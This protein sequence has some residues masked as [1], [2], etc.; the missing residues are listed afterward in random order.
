MKLNIQAVYDRAGLELSFHRQATPARRLRMR[1]RLDS[2]TL[3][4]STRAHSTRTT[5][6]TARTN[7]RAR[8]LKFRRMAWRQPRRR[9]CS[10][11]SFPA[12]LKRH[13]LQ[14]VNFC[15]WFIYSRCTLRVAQNSFN[16][17]LVR[18]LGRATCLLPQQI[19]RTEKLA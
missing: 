7:E 12:A 16:Y 19:S 9:Q 15:L 1:Q 14:S 5:T 10:L 11:P 13:P 3:F 4:P 17:S 8:S 6:R 18:L 2:S